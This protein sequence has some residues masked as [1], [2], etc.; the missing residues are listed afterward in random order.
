MA[1]SRSLRRNAVLDQ[2]EDGLHLIS[3][4]DAEPRSAGVLERALGPSA[5]AAI[6]LGTM[7]GTGIFLKPGE[8]AQNAGSFTVMAAAWVA[9][10]ILSVFGGLCYAELGASLPEAGGE[11]AYLRRAFGPRTGFLFG[12]THSTVARPA[13]VAAIAAGFMRFVGFFVPSLSAPVFSMHLPWRFGVLALSR[14]QT[15]ALVALTAMTGINYLG[16]RLGGRVQVVLTVIKVG[17]LLTVLGSVFLLLHHPHLRSNVQPFWPHSPSWGTLEGFLTAMAAAA[18]AYDGWNDLNLVGS[19]VENPRTNFPRIIIR[20]VLFVIAV[21]LLFNFACFWVLPYGRVAASQQITSEVFEIVAGHRAALWITGIMA[22]SVLATLNS[23]ILSGARVDY[24]MAR[25]GVFFRCAAAV[26]PRFRT[27]GNAL[28]LQCAIAGVLVLSGSFEDLTSLVMFAN[29]GFYA[30]AVLAMMRLRQS[31]P[32]LERPYRTWGYPV[33]PILFVIGGFSL[34]ISLWIARPVRSTIGAA[35]I[36]SGLFFY[37]LWT[38]E[39]ADGSLS[40]EPL[41]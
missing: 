41:R 27:P 26:H 7:V 32:A 6:V 37:R 16:V 23:S 15:W 36:L 8:V 33:T 3:T 9:A 40:S 24:A 34:S 10:G 2:P 13:S 14:G 39:D 18:W 31:E 25:D 20:G 17:A 5:A 29:W 12:W 1:R 30:T 4:A 11:Y 19:E 21:F 38:R 28:L 35:V 22:V